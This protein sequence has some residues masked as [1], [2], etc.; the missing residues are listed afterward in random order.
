MSELGPVRRLL[1]TP[2]Q[3]ADDKARRQ[4]ERLD[5]LLGVAGQ[6]ASRVVELS[7]AEDPGYDNIRASVFT[8]IRSNSRVVS[9]PNRHIAMPRRDLE[10]LGE[11]T[12]RSSGEQ[13]RAAVD[14]QRDALFRLV[15]T[16]AEGAET[17]LRDNAPRSRLRYSREDDRQPVWEF[18]ETVNRIWVNENFGRLVNRLQTAGIVDDR[19]ASDLDQP[20]RKLTENEQVVNGFLDRMSEKAGMDS[21]A[22]VEMVHLAPRNQKSWQIAGALMRN[23]PLREL[24]GDK[25]REAREKLST[26]IDRQVPSLQWPAGRRQQDVGYSP[27]SVSGRA[28]ERVLSALAELEEDMAPADPTVQ[29]VQIF[30]YRQ[31]MASPGSASTAHVSGDGA[32]SGAHPTA[33]KDRGPQGIG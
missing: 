29:L 11:L 13:D 7:G 21:V 10:L 19:T 1:R 17:P 20:P 22:F 25:G 15:S 18:H 9:T 6:I 4:Q 16:V 33:K 24:P 2:A 3:R 5:R 12:A 26:A 28:T 27:A 31:G 23:S 8:A 32:A 30:D 14:A